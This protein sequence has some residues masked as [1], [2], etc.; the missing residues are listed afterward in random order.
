MGAITDISPFSSVCSVLVNIC[1]AGGSR[2]KAEKKSDRLKIRAR[3]TLNTTDGEWRYKFESVKH[4]KTKTLNTQVTFKV[5]L[6][7]WV[8]SD[9]S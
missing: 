5:L 4:F 6:G 9:G 8:Q 1:V 3:N 7:I 2:D